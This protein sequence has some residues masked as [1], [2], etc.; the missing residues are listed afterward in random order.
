MKDKEKIRQYLIDIAEKIFSQLGFDRTTMD[1]IAREARKGKSTLYYY[2]KNKEQLFAAVV[3]KEAEYILSELLEIVNS[4]LD[5]RSTLKQYA[6]KRF[7]LAR[8][9]LNYYHV[10]KNEDYY[11]YYPLVYK[12]RRK[13]DEYEVKLIK[14]ILIKG[15]EARE[16][17]IDEQNI[18]SIAVAITAAMRGLEEPILLDNNHS[19]L[20]EK[21]DT[22]VDILFDGLTNIIR[23]KHKNSQ[24]TN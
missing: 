1:I 14:Q 13:H 9:L 18:Q 6:N 20:E 24:K 8:D 4:P 16:I 15:I 21:I 12:Y 10:I 3:Q 5:A 22:M 7:Q 11:R 2:F 19:S 23:T 17:D